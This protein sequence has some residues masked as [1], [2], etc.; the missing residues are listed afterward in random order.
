[1]KKLMRTTNNHIKSEAKKSIKS[2]FKPSRTK[3]STFS[4][5]AYEWGKTE[6]GKGRRSN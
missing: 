6:E 2:L 3:K 5:S 4:K 1:M